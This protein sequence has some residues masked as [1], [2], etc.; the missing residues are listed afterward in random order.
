LNGAGASM[1]GVAVEGA[2]GRLLPEVARHPALNRFVSEAIGRS[3]SSE[4]ELELEGRPTRSVRATAEPLRDPTGRSLGV[5]VSLQDITRI[6]RLESLRSDFVSNVS[7]ELRTPI[8][9]IKGYVETLLQIGSDDPV[10]VRKFLEVVQRNTTRLSN[11]VEDLLALASLEQDSVGDRNAI[12]MHPVSAA[13]IVQDV[14]EQLAPH[15]E[16]RRIRLERT[17]TPGLRV[18]VNRVLAE[19][20]LANLVSNAARYAKEG[21]RVRI[22]ARE[23]DAASAEFAVT[24]EGPGIA[25][26]HLERIFERFYRVDRSRARG[27]TGSGLADGGGTGLGL[28]IVK[29]IAQVHGGRVEVESTLGVGSTFRLVLPRAAAPNEN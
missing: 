3:E 22:H 7:H 2:R 6:R 20:A 19:Q 9:A 8:T 11:L 16:A 5:L 17:S 13:S 28:A 23:L 25:P 4:A 15:A 21:T 12:E 18:V 1:L 29:H 10:R 27:P 24:D 26:K 14:C